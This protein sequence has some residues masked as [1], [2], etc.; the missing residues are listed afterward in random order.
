MVANLA[1]AQQS[2]EDKFKADLENNK[3]KLYVLGGIASRATPADEK[4]SEK[5]NI[6]YYD[7]G[8]LAPPDFNYYTNYNH[9]VLKYLDKNFR[10]EWINDI[11]KDIIGWNKWKNINRK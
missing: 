6:S 2:P 11:R 5:Y 10:S 9:T 7:F 4:F 3:I 8:C 1:H